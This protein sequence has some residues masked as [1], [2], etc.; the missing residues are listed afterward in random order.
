MWMEVETAK[1]EGR[2]ELVLTGEVISERVSKSD[3]GLDE[4]IF[5]L[6]NLNFLEISRADIRELPNK[7]GQ[8][9]NLTNL[10]LHSNKL[11][12]IPST[13][14]HLK[15]L[16]FLDISKNELKKLPVE[17]G[18]LKELQTLN[19][20]CNKLTEFVDVGQMINLHILDVSHNQLK[21]LP[22]GLACTELNLLLTVLANDN[23]IEQL[24]L[25]L[26][27][28]PSLKL[29]DVSNNMIEDVPLEL[30]ECGKLKDFKCS[31]NRLK[32]KRL[33][34]MVDQCSTKA[35]LDYLKNLL[36]KEHKNSGKKGNSGDKKKKG[37]KNKDVAVE[38]VAQNL[39]KVLHFNSDDGMIV[40]AMA[41][42][43]SV[44]P[45]IVCCI[46][47]NVN[48][49]KSKSMMKRFILLQVI[50]MSVILFLKLCF[51]LLEY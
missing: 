8:L 47:R 11:V 38:D 34:K 46:V 3:Q 30:S 2:R 13:L 16:K 50:F 25:E 10:V 39:M 9:V 1:S 20:N 37:G 51:E 31:G 33:S 40:H 22:P 48:F 12:E 32:D 43:Q 24:P 4:N 18:A 26:N 49:S 19:V 14:G 28:L 27:E 35:V 29:L 45:F 6:T 42:V 23:Q 21:Q 17:I 44:R 41:P 36:E 5:S 7:V 15:K